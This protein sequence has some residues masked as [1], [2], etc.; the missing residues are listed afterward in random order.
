MSPTNKINGD[1][2]AKDETDNMAPEVGFGKPPIAHRFPPGKSGNPK[3]R[4]KTPKTFE[5]A[6]LKSLNQRVNVSDGKSRRK[7]TMNEVMAKRLINDAAT[8][9]ISAVREV[10]KGMEKLR[11]SGMIKTAE[12][13][14]RQKTY[15][16]LVFHLL[17][18]FGE[19]TGELKMYFKSV[20]PLSAR[21]RLAHD[22]RARNNVETAELKRV[23]E[24]E[25]PLVLYPAKP[26]EGQR[27]LETRCFKALNEPYK[28]KL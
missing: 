20:G 11:G 23:A 18:F 14:E 16:D 13:M 10:L 9:K 24:L 8:G 21:F 5:E 27:V 3:G 28:K 7:M 12:E 4:P 22:T 17:E 1:N 25:P 15:S 2:E 26:G 19:A 6:L